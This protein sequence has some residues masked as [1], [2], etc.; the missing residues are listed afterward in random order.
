MK[1]F[2]ILLVICCLVKIISNQQDQCVR[3]IN[4]TIPITAC[5]KI[6][7]LFPSN[8]QH[9]VNDELSQEE[10]EQKSFYCKF[11][12]KMFEKSNVTSLNQADIVTNFEKIVTDRDWLGVI[13]SN[14]Q[15]C[16]DFSFKNVDSYQIKINATKEECDGVFCQFMDCLVL[17]LSIVSIMG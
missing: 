5:C 7:A 14:I 15:K 16:I 13:K 1:T 6:T 4:K 11:W 8:A 9:Q 10:K 2:I 3:W 12:Q 17:L